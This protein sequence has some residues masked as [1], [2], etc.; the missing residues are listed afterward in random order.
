MNERFLEAVKKLNNRLDTIESDL[1]SQ[2]KEFEDYKTNENQLDTQKIANRLERY[3]VKDGKWFY[4]EFDTGESAIGPQGEQ[5][6]QGEPFTFDDLTEEQ[7][8]L[9]TGADGKD[10]LNGKDGAKGEPGKDGKDGKDGL[11]GKDGKDGKDAETP[12]F[13]IG[14]VKS[15]S[16]YDPAKVALSKEGNL[17][18]LT[19]DIPR[20]RPGKD[21]ADGSNGSG[22]SG[23]G[24]EIL[25]T[26]DSGK[27][28]ADELKLV[29]NN[30]KT[31]VINNDGELFYLAN[32]QSDLTYKTY[33][34]FDVADSTSIEGKAIYIQ[35][36]KHSVNFGK[37]TKEDVDFPGGTADFDE[38]TNRPKYN[39]GLMDSTTDIPEV[40]IVETNYSEIEGH[41]YDV[42]YINTLVGNVES[43]MANLYNG[44]GAE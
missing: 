35:L 19:F 16:T 30:E 17:Y 26:G 10:G 15:V 42:T 39:G 2:K 1:K 18:T 11:N 34:N 24:I 40:P 4:D 3:R 29:A 5:G 14:E 25:L 22:G 36:D 23:N 41:V 37:W 43:L 12:N 32:K 27:L 6:P 31:V 9:L 21:G 13:K 28:T 20:G 33:V 44:G 8:I 7:I 38:L